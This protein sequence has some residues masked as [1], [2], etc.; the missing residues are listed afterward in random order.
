MS[1]WR[2][3]TLDIAVLLIGVISAKQPIHPTIINETGEYYMVFDTS[4][5]DFMN[6]S[7][8]C[9]YYNTSNTLQ[10]R[11]CYIICDKTQGCVNSTINCHSSD[12]CSIDCSSNQSCSFAL[13]N[14]FKTNNLTIDCNAYTS[15]E[16]LDIFYNNTQTVNIKCNQNY[17]CSN[18]NIN[19]NYSQYS[20]ISCIYNNSCYL[21]QIKLSNVNNVSLLCNGSIY[22]F[23]YKTSPACLN[24]S[25]T[26]INSTFVNITSGV[27]MKYSNIIVQSAN[28]FALYTMDQNSVAQTWFNLYDIETIFLS[29]YDDYSCFQSTF[30]IYDK[31][32]VTWWCG[33]RAHNTDYTSGNSP[34]FLSTLHALNANSLNVVLN[35]LDTSPINIYGPQYYINISNNTNNSNKMVSRS[36]IKCIYYGCI[37]LNYF[38]KNGLVDWNIY[39]QL[40]GCDELCN[41]F[42][43]KNWI[44]GHEYTACVM[45]WKFNCGPLFKL[46]GAYDPMF[47]GPNCNGVCCNNKT[48]T[49]IQQQFKVAKHEHDNQCND[50][51]LNSTDYIMLGG[52]CVLFLIIVGLC[53]EKIRRKNKMYPS[54]L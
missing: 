49:Q 25:M 15:C 1:C 47:A 35:A 42:Y 18:I 19:G 32:N 36:N 16:Q 53:G 4:E 41:S 10:P 27:Q 30:N 43:P 14:S 20:S 37:E 31:S 28:N 3:K 39:F 52:A 38:S 6:E 29:C 48:F 13:I 24:I 2:V 40:P 51:D 11:N 9:N 8:I 34:C 17:S 45:D 23:R 7:I 12:S 21:S 54:L 50:I 22:N 46:T 44:D 33:Y 5:Y 26:T